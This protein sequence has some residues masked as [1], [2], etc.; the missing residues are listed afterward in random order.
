MEWKCYIFPGWWEQ[1]FSRKVTFEPNH[2]NAVIFPPMPA[3]SQG[4]CKV[5]GAHS[6]CVCVCPGF[7]LRFSWEVIFILSGSPRTRESVSYFLGLCCKRSKP[8]V[9][10]SAHLE[11]VAAACC[12]W[13]REGG[14]DRFRGLFSQH[15]RPFPSLLPLVSPWKGPH[16]TAVPFGW[17]GVPAEG[18][19]DISWPRCPVHH[20]HCGS[21]FEKQWM[22]MTQLRF[23]SALDTDNSLKSEGRVNLQPHIVPSSAIGFLFAHL[24][25]CRPSLLSP[26]LPAA[27]LSLPV[28]FFT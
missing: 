3:T 4:P 25:F 20:S 9:A 17:P 19:E 5:V 24:C 21:A 22:L 15:H 18:S 7:S 8:F 23:P 1:Q 13:S 6:G 16:C 11:M 14:H 28:L 12:S 2:G 26:L 27:P 10:W